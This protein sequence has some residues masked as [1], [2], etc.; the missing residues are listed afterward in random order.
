MKKFILV[1]LI[2]IALVVPAAAQLRIDVGLM[3]PLGIGITNLPE[4]SS[5]LKDLSET[6]TK[7]VWLFLPEVGAY[8]ELK[9]D[10]LPLKLGFGARAF[11]F[12]VIGA[13]WPNVFAELQLGP[14]FVEAQLGGLFFGYYALNDF[15]GEFGKVFLPDLSAWIALGQKKSFRLGG[16]ALMFYAPEFVDALADSTG[17]VLVPF[18]YYASAKFVIRP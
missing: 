16:G 13:A 5:E 12:L 9:L 3:K 1:L 14:V 6:M 2:A 7:Q 15:G 10:P 18:I 17:R 4:A 11:S 8:Y